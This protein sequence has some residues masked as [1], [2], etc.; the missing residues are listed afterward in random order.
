MKTPTKPAWLS[1]VDTI[2][3]ELCMTI[4]SSAAPPN[5]FYSAI[6]NEGFQISHSGE[7]RFASASLPVL[8][9][10]SGMMLHRSDR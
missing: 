9:G 4:Q 8:D 7:L 2:A 5:A 1:Q 6:E 3:I 10:I